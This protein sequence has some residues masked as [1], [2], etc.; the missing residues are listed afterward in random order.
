MRGS[1]LVLSVT[2]AACGAEPTFVELPGS[3][4]VPGPGE[5]VITEFML[6]PGA[7]EAASGQYL[8]LL[9]LSD[10]PLDLGRMELGDGV[11]TFTL[12]VVT[13]EPRSFALAVPEGATPCHGVVPQLTFGGLLGGEGR[14]RI[15][16]TSGKGLVD[17]VVFEGWVGEPG[18]AWSLDASVVTAEGN[19]DASAWCPS[20]TPIAGTADRGTPGRVNEVCAVPVDTEVVADTE[21]AVDTEEPGD[22]EVPVDTDVP[23]DTEA[24]IDTDPPPET[25]VAVDT[26]VPDTAPPQDTFETDLGGDTDLPIDT[27]PGLLTVND[28]VVGNLIIT[29]FF[30]DPVDCDDFMAEYIELYNPTNDFIDPTG[31][32]IGIGGQDGPVTVLDLIPPRSF[33]VAR[34]STGSPPGCYGFPGVMRYG[35]ARMDATGPVLRIR[36]GALILDEVVLSG[37]PAFGPGVAVELDPTAMSPSANDLAASWCPATTHVPGGTNDLG[38]PGQPNTGCLGG[39]TGTP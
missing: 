6:E 7:C 10:R 25:D 11:E 22:T 13:L 14:Q 31:L 16:L 37:W 29:E 28:L 18:S 5:V 12:P 21:V 26:E 15:V 20:A 38:S 32:Q 1:A 30:P 35:A 4:D 27:D 33:V 39:D 36:R 9:N 24:P 8:E 19:D 23:A 34:Y 3:I 2:L 17:E